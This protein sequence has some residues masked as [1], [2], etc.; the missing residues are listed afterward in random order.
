MNP[1][2]GEVEGDLLHVAT[3]N[4]RRPLPRGLSRGADRWE[5]RRP[6]LLASLSRESPSVISL[7]EVLPGP[8]RDIARA[9]GGEYG[10]IGVGRGRGGRGEG[11]PIFFD[12]SRLELIDH[13]QLA[14]SASPEVAGSRSWGNP[15]PR[16]MV[17]GVFRDRLARASFAVI[18]THLDPFS[19]RSRVRAA[20]Q[21]RQVVRRRGLP[22]V[23]MGDMNAAD[24]SRALEALT[25]GDL[26]TDAWTTAAERVTPPWGTY[27]GYRPPVRGGE[28]IDWILTTPDVA[29]E[30]VGIDARLEDGVAGSDHLPVHAAIEVPR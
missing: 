1:V 8:A 11:C 21:I 9:L 29:V 12:R 13:Q 24:G 19:S 10:R 6:A 14:L 26:L 20:E 17:I 16:A 28:R 22:T 7:Q 25:R 30:R 3:L 27:S 2:L 23:V 18:N 15:L 4:V 5:R